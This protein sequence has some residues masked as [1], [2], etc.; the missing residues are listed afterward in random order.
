V[1]IVPA[2]YDL[3]I[4]ARDKF[5]SSGYVFPGAVKG[6]ACCP[7]AIESLFHRQLH[8]PV[9]CHGFRSTLRD[10]LGDCTSVDRD[11]AEQLPAHHTG[12][13]EGAYRRSSSLEK[14]KQ[15]LE[16]WSTFVTGGSV[17]NVVQFRVEG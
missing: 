14:R 17:D 12:G 2:I 13:V 3:L 11:T 6:S 7:R 9:S 15:A 1:P 8:V 5:G 10:W 4:E 16:L